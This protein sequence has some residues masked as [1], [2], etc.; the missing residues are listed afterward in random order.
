MMRALGPGSVSSF[1]KIILDVVFA[2]LWIGLVVVPAWTSYSTVWERLA[3]AFLS[4]Y[5]LLAG[6]L[7]GGVIG[8][9]IVYFWID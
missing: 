7:I 1:L 5:V 4:L 6:A 2:A 8:G 9:A 3:A